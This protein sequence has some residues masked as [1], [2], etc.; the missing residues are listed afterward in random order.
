MPVYRQPKGY[1]FTPEKSVEK[2]FHDHDETWIVLSGRLKAFM[3]DRDG[4]TDEFELT[5]GDVWMIE[6]GVEHGCKILSDEAVI[7][8]FPGTLPE[9]CHPPAHYDMEKEG[10]MPTL[11]LVK[12]PLDRYAKE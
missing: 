12:E 11:K 10:Y 1:T 6:A 8:P 2:H 7:F 3:I 9:G 5:A 4:T